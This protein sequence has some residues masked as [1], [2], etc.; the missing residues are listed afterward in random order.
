MNTG[1]DILFLNTPA[2][3]VDAANGDDE[4]YLRTLSPNNAVWNVQ[5]TLIGGSP[6]AGGTDNDLVGIDTPGDNTVTYTP[7]SANS[8][9]FV[10]AQGTNSVV[11]INTIEHLFYD[12]VGGNDTVTVIATAG[13]DTITHTPGVAN[14]QGNFRVNNLLAI[15]YQ[16]LCAT[17]TLTL[18]GGTG[19]DTL[20]ALGTDINDL[21]IVSAGTGAVTLN[22]R[23]ALN[24]T[25][26]EGLML[27]GQDGD[28]TFNVPGNHPYIAGLSIQ[29]GDP[30]ASDVVNFTAS[31]TV[32]NLVTVD[33]GASTVQESTFGP[34]S[35]SGVEVLNTNTNGH[36]LTING[37]LGDDASA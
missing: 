13:N 6:S 1:P 5:V 27:S 24:Q 32:A 15:D 23:L 29:G 10:L 8:G 30:S 4:I 28:D 16:S 25:A 37:T 34:L 36:N 35:L 11:T 9:S 19:S 7:T 17:S 31:A 22:T 14:N 18:D 12:G 20:I 33:F 26:V 2:L 21:F 3:T